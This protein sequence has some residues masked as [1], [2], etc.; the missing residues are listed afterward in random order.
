ME[1]CGLLVVHVV[2]KSGVSSVAHLTPNATNERSTAN[3]LAGFG[4]LKRD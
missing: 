1:L 4:F 2:E 3:S